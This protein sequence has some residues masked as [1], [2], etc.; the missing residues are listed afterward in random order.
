MPVTTGLCA[1]PSHSSNGG[2][3]PVYIEH[4]PPPPQQQRLRSHAHKPSETAY[5]TPPSL[6][7][8]QRQLR[9]HAHGTRGSACFHRCSHSS[10]PTLWGWTGSLRE[11]QR[12]PH[13]FPSTEEKSR[14]QGVSSPQ[15]D[16]TLCGSRTTLK[17]L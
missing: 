8:Q 5:Q 15:K 16:L 12:C 1:R 17:R 10:A 3:T 6:P 4:P 7:Q 2:H 11:R 14:A 9:A 13:P